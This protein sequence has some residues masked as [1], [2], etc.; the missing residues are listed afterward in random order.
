MKIIQ[1]SSFLCLSAYADTLDQISFFCCLYICH[2]F[3]LFNLYYPQDFHL[4][5][6]LGV[7]VT[8][9]AVNLGVISTIMGS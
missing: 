6:V 7:T 8:P 4:K 5:T 9:S 2:M 3:T 1:V